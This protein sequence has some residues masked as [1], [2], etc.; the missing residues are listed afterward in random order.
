MLGSPLIYFFAQVPPN[1][2]GLK[3]LGPPPKIGAA[4]TMLIYEMLLKVK[5]FAADKGPNLQ[6]PKCPST[7]GT[8]YNLQV[9]IRPHL[10]YA[11]IIYDKAFNESFHTKLESLQ[12]TPH[13][14]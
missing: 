6:T 11:D 14:P 10:D 4:A 1:F 12:L 9:I 7:I 8:S 2:F 3:F 13:W 5:Y